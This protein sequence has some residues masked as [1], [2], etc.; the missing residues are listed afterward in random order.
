MFGKNHVFIDKVLSQLNSSSN[1]CL[2]LL[3]QWLSTNDTKNPRIDNL[4]II[5]DKDD[6]KD[7]KDLKLFYVK[8][9]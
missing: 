5:N 2:P 4:V 9:M 7:L 8:I 6:Y 3:H 1:I